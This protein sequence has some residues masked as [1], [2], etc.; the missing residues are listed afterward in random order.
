M[1]VD[2]AVAA[3]IDIA[4]IPRNSFARVLVAHDAFRA[5]LVIA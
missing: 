4:V 2:V 5:R 1:P 3:R